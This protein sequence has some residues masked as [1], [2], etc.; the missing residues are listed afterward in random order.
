MSLK[1]FHSI[2][3]VLRFWCCE[4]HWVFWSEYHW[5]CLTVSIIGCFGVSIIGCGSRRCTAKHQPKWPPPP[6]SPSTS[7]LLKAHLNSRFSLWAEA[8]GGKGVEIWEGQIKCRLIWRPPTGLKPLLTL[9]LLAP[10]EHSFSLY[11]AACR[12]ILK[13][14]KL[15]YATLLLIP[16]SS[17]PR[18]SVLLNFTP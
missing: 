9:T 14:S 15:Y 11:P 1:R 8:L 6:P 17:Y 5:V 16:P 3:S 13:Y 4:Y 2:L 10:K 7:C 18:R 12:P